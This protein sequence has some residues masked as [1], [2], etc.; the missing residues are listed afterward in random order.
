MCI[1]R[2]PPYLEY[3]PLC[4]AGVFVAGVFVAI[5]MFSILA[6]HMLPA[7]RKPKALRIVS[8]APCGAHMSRLVR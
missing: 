5:G 7:H 6:T 1:I 4:R 3:A 8:A 2:D